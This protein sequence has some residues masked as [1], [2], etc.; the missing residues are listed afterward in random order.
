MVGWMIHECMYERPEEWVNER[1][2]EHGKDECKNEWMKEWVNGRMDEW[3]GGWM[4]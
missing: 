2:I 4:K 3:V 1:V